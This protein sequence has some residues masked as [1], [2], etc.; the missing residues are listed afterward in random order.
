MS[1][2][3]ILNRLQDIRLTS[4]V[5]DDTVSVV[6]YYEGRVILESEDIETAVEK[7]ISYLQS[8]VNDLQ[9]LA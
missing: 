9:E 8:T 2:D 4:G 3:E 7:Y 6:D 5:T 1:R